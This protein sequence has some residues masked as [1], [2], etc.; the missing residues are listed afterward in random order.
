MIG[1]VK[2]AIKVF[3][4]QTASFVIRFLTSLLV[5]VWLGAEG[6][7]L[8]ASVLLVPTI[9]ITLGELGIRQSIVFYLGRKIYSINE[10][11]NT[12]DYNIKVYII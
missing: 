9:L 2:D 4:G 1:A 11:A 6:K 5:A 7:G 3:S 10:I 8:Y 12:N